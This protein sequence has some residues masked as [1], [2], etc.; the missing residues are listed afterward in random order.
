MA[1]NSDHA[2]DATEV[3]VSREL[4]MT[5]KVLLWGVVFGLLMLLALLAYAWL[6]GGFGTPAPRT[7]AENALLTTA[8]QIQADP[9]AGTAY[10]TRAE[11]LYALG[12][13]AEAYQVLQQGKAAVGKATPPLLYVL[14]TWTA[15]LIK[16]GNFVQAE[17]VGKEGMLA[18]DDYL[19]RQG[20]ALAAKKVTAIN[21]NLITGESVDM[22]VQL[23]AAYMAEKKYD[24]ALE[25]YNYAY[26]LEPLG[27]DVQTLRGYC[28]LAMGNKA[29]AKADFT[30]ALTYL[31]NDPSAKSG[32]AQASK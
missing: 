4:D 7:A 6:S 11:T 15:L 3:I 18:S 1:N 19:A 17:K 12:R 31:P 21:A 16:D 10:A 23:A 25:L 32:L 24:K 30:E 2:I 5:T 28:Y 22:S 9:K 26:Q 14:R 29:K 27:A 8:A 20:A 13:K